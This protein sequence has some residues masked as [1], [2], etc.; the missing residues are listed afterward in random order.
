MQSRRYMEENDCPYREKDFLEIEI[1][2]FLTG[3]YMIPISVEILFRDRKVRSLELTILS[4]GQADRPNNH[5]ATYD[6]VEGVDKR[7]SY[8]C[9]HS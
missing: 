6:A 1:K 7:C 2:T 9:T 4:P 3:Q 5:T 8:C